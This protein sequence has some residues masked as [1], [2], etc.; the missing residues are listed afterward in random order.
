MDPIDRFSGPA[1]NEPS[2]KA[3][4][5]DTGDSRTFLFLPVG[6]RPAD[7]PR[8][9]IGPLG[10]MHYLKSIDLDKLCLFSNPA[11]KAELKRRG[12]AIREVSAEMPPGMLLKPTWCGNPRAP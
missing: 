12:Y 5:Y 1:P 2:V 8:A 3:D 7:L 11:I 6:R 10:R 9:L 4:L